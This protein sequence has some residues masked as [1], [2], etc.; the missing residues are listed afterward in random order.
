MQARP[1]EDVTPDREKRLRQGGGLLHAQSSGYRQAL[2]GGSNA[3]LGVAAA[4]Q[5]RADRVAD[6][7]VI[8]ARAE[9]NDGSGDFQSRDV[10]SAR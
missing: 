3:I 5:Q 2:W 4:G 10:G 7:P 6:S 1:V 8:R 9:R